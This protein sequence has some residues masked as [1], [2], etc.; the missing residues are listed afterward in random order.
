M[1]FKMF[2]ICIEN[3]VVTEMTQLHADKKVTDTSSSSCGQD[4]FGHLRVVG[5]ADGEKTFIL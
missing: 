3:H 4:I 2:D 5:I 1:T